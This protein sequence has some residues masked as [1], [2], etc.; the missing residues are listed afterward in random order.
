MAKQVVESLVDDLNGDSADETVHFSIDGRNY[1]I[2][3][4]SKNA[5]GLRDAVAPFVGAARRAGGA[6]ARKDYQRTSAVATKTREENAA[7]RQWAGEN[8]L[9]VSERGRLPATVLAAYENLNSPAAAEPEAP[10][11]EAEEKPKRRS[12]KKATVDA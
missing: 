5:S 12:R 2:D 9:E 6:Q 3:L 1:E 8:G 7:I 11:V 10:A 4:T